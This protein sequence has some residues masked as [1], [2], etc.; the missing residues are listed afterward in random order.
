MREI[1]WRIEEGIRINDIISGKMLSIRLGPVFVNTTP[2]PTATP[3]VKKDSTNKKKEREVVVEVP[4]RP[5]VDPRSL[6]GQCL[7]Q[8]K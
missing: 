4:R 3:H 1:D 7:L 8:S 2:G 5:T 6:G